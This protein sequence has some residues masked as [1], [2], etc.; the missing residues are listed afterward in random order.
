MKTTPY[1]TGKVQIGLY[2]ERPNNYWISMDMERLQT[3]YIGRGIEKTIAPIFVWL[4]VISL[5]SLAMFWVC[6]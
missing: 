1:D 5:V 2:Y 6:R 3:A 4:Y